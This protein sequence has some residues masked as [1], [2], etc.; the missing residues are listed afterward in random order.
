[1]ANY[2]KLKF[3]DIDN[4]IGAFVIDIH[5]RTSPFALWGMYVMYQAFPV[6]LRNA[7]MPPGESWAMILDIA[8][9]HMTWFWPTVIFYFLYHPVCE[10]LMHGDSFGKRWMHIHVVDVSGKRPTPW[11]ILLR[12]FWR[13]IE[14]LPVAWLWGYFAILRSDENARYG[15]IA[16][17]T[18]VVAE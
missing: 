2:G 16:S 12:N 7:P 6:L 5:I 18:R 8:S 3:A 11:Q 14:F 4:R 1:M 17:R 13:A 15:D 9:R 10:L